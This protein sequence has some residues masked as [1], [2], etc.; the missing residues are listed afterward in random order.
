MERKT[1]KYIIGSL[2]LLSTAFFIYQRIALHT[3]DFN[4][5]SLN[6]QY[7]FSQGNYFEPLRPPLAGFILGIFNT[8][9]GMKGAEIC[10]ILVVSTIFCISTMFLART[11]KS[12][13][14][15][16]YLLSLNAYLL[17][18]GLHEG[19]ELLSLSFIE[20]ALA[21]IIRNNSFSGLFLGLAFLTRYTNLT[22]IP[23]LIL[24]G[25][26]KKIMKSLSLVILVISPWLIYNYAHYGNMFTSFADLYAINLAYQSSS[27]GTPQI[28]DLLKVTNLLLPLII[29]GAYSFKI[30]NTL[31]ISKTS[32]LMVLLAL[33]GVLV[34]LTTP[35]KTSRYLFVLILPCIYLAYQGYVH[36]QRKSKRTPLILAIIVILSFGS[37]IAITHKTISD[38][39]Y[40]QKPLEYLKEHNL[41]E[42]SIL[43]NRWVDLTYRGIQ[44]SPIPPQALFKKKIEQGY[45]L[46]LFKETHTQTYGLKQD[47]LFYN[48]TATTTIAGNGCLPRRTYNLLFTEQARENIYEQYHYMININPC[49][50]LFRS[51]DIAEKTCNAINGNGFTQDPNRKFA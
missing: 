18:Y 31:K 46:V 5:Y 17:F 12:N 22:I 14:V 4:A 3:W 19:T 43:S 15:V 50:I 44:A 24:H 9:L 39:S 10:F 6:G 1:S 38:P 33:Q 26:I 21:L 7:L 35:Y 32:I 36:L 23:F 51:S 25:N 42:C 40:Y 8:L 37:A 41:S 47:Y 45:I 20:L 16:F 28:I 29:L 30:K 48:Q 34:Y 11:L 49:F 27:S 2:Y 13:E